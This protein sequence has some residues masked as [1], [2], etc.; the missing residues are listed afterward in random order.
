MQG[1]C[2]KSSWETEK[3][4]S[5]T[6]KSSEIKCELDGETEKASEIE[7]NRVRVADFV[8][9]TS[10]NSNDTS[11]KK[12]RNREWKVDFLDPTK[13]RKLFFRILFILP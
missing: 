6:D 12:M 8:L 11:R 3:S 2:D 9:N 1:D 7:R 5:D 4:N 10:R 13:M